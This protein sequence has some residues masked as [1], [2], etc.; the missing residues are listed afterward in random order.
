MNYD[1]LY[2]HSANTYYVYVYL[3]PRKTGHY[4]CISASM[5]YEPFYVG[6][7][8]DNRYRIHLSLKNKRHP[9]YSKIN[10]IKTTTGDDPYTV[11]LAAFDTEEEAYAFEHTLIERL[12]CSSIKLTNIKPGGADKGL[13]YKQTH[14]GKRVS[15]FKNIPRSEAV[16]Q[17]I[18]TSKKQHNPNTKRWLAISPEGKNYTPISLAQLI[19]DELGYAPSGYKALINVH[20]DGRHHVKRGQ[21]KGW[22]I[23]ALT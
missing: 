5:C 20:L 17:K 10:K 11:I 23:Y 18:S 21:M 7:G 22:Q 14:S 15:K 16:K 3:D 9:F 6:K 12:L 2:R 1:T 19:V 8:T 13:T 4:D